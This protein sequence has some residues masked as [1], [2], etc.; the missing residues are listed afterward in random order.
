MYPPMYKV[1]M[2]HVIY[3]SNYCVYLLYSLYAQ[4]KSDF[5]LKKKKKLPKSVHFLNSFII[6]QTNS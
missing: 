6:L 1:I 3:L 5:H 4:A 2:C